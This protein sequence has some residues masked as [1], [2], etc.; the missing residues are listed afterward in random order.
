MILY[1]HGLE[2]SAQGRKATWLRERYDV[3]CPELNTKSMIHLRDEALAGRWTWD[4]SDPRMLEALQMPLKQALSAIETEPKPDLIIGSS[5]GGA[6]LLELINS[7]RWSGPSLFL[8]Q[9]G[10]RVTTRSVIPKGHRAILVH[11]TADAVIPFS[12]SEAL[13]DDGRIP[14]WPVD[15]DHMLRTILTNGTLSRAID[16]LL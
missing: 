6:L 2:S 4:P 11:G 9:A 8:A 16:A 12:D 14:L 7:G 10:L 5:F 15:D 1:L 3:R 13:S